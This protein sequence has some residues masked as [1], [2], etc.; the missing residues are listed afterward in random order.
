MEMWSN[1]CW[2][3]LQDN[4]R[5]LFGT[6]K[7]QRKPNTLRIAKTVAAAAAVAMKKEQRLPCPKGR[8]RPITLVQGAEIALVRVKFIYVWLLTPLVESPDLL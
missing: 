1:I 8:S 3:K 6:L 5:R 4:L 2:Y 7:V